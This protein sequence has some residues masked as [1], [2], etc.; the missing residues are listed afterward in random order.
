M[1]AQV[2][3][4]T[5]VYHLLELE[6]PG[7]AI[8]V[9]A[10]SSEYGI[11]TLV[12]PAEYVPW[13]PASLVPLGEL[14]TGLP[15]ADGQQVAVALFRVSSR[16]AGLL[17]PYSGRVP[18]CVEQR[19]PSAAG[20]RA[21][22]CSGGDLRV[23]PGGSAARLGRGADARGACGESG[24]PGPPARW[25]A[26][27]RPVA[28]GHG[29]PM[30]ATR[31]RWRGDRSGG[32][33]RRAGALPGRRGRG[34]GS[35]GRRLLLGPGGTCARRCASGFGLARGAARF[36]VRPAARPGLRRGGRR[37]GR[38]WPTSSSSEQ[39]GRCCPRRPPLASCR[40]ERHSPRGPCRRPGGSSRISCCPAKHRCGGWEGVG[41]RGR[42]WQR[43]GC[44]PSRSCPSQGSGP[45]SQPHPGYADCP[46][47]PDPRRATHLRVATG[48]SGGSP[49]TSPSFSGGFQHLGEWRGSR[50]R[51]WSPAFA[52]AAKPVG[53]SSRLAQYGR[54]PSVLEVFHFVRLRAVWSPPR[55]LHRTG[56]ASHLRRFPPGHRP[57]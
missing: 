34:G 46:A 6:L 3:A 56:T 37:W 25:G 43:A 33:G 40:S 51:G 12:L 14:D 38:R 55:S 35:R 49:H 8:P 24:H 5:L 15:V 16:L 18:W 17:V 9:V 22:G 27:A 31:A 42:A 50:P 10:V 52:I 47:L 23:H 2:A 7:I 36:G 57:R 48:P 39:L 41:S 13:L 28:S 26:L 29:H 4:A 1:A 45:S 53:W 32:S 44:T 20:L 30:A 54:G 11:L 21:F 19:W